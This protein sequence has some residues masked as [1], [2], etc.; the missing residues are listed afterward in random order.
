MSP[1]A[2]H[3]LL[4]RRT[5]VHTGMH[6]LIGTMHHM[7]AACRIVH[8]ILGIHQQARRGSGGR[9]LGWQKDLEKGGGSL[10]LQ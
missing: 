5:L 8:S 10:T 1:G 7:P 2:F 6:V 9:A 3:L 4:L